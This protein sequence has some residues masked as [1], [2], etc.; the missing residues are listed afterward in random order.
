MATELRKSIFEADD[1][2]R[3]VVD[4]PEWEVKVEVRGM[5]GKARATFLRRATNPADGTL[6]YEK[7]YPELLI[8]TIHDPESG[9]KVFESADRDAI[10]EKSGAALERLALVAQ[11]LS[12]LGAA[13]VEAAKGNS[14]SSQ[15]EGST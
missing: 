4:V 10:N 2:G 7:F 5:N 3:E 6:E 13:D 14:E 1:I 11:R 15:S 8:A 12:G 9:E